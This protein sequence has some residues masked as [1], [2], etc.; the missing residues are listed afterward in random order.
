MSGF[1]EVLP[2]A[3]V[4]YA[5]RAAQAAAEERAR[6]RGGEGERDVHK[7]ME[8]GRVRAR[9]KMEVTFLAN[10]S[11]KRPTPYGLSVWESGKGLNGEGDALCWFC[12]DDAPDSNEGCRSIIPQDCV[13]ADVS[14]CPKCKRIKNPTELTTALGGNVY[15]DV[16]AKYLA[17]FWKARC[18]SDADI[19]LKYH[20]DDVRYI[21]MLK[22]K[23]AA[24]AEKL[25]GLHIYPLERILRDLLTGADLSKR[26]KA[27][28]TS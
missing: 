22:S 2:S 24:K 26:I 9:W 12:L 20:K 27:F 7:V 4:S 1:R 13:Q 14:A 11:M 23:G 18:G 25:K 8:G 10:R 21:A 15:P 5:T 3:Q 17:E 19:Y 28:I 6:A 16:L